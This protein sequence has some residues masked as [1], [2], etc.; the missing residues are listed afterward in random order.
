MNIFLQKTVVD[1]GLVMKLER[2][3]I[4]SAFI[5]YPSPPFNSNPEDRLP[6]KLG[7]Q[8]LHRPQDRIL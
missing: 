2:I 8:R 1:L 6:K 4:A 7:A 3:S 5:E